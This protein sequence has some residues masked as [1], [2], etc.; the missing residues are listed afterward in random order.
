LGLFIPDP[1]FYPSRNQG[2]K[3]HRI[4]DPQRC[5]QRRII[6]E[7]HI[8]FM[9]LVGGS[10]AAFCVDSKSTKVRRLN[11]SWSRVQFI[12][13]FLRLEQSKPKIF[14]SFT[15][16]GQLLQGRSQHLPL[17]RPQKPLQG[18]PQ[19]Q[20][21]DS[22]STCLQADIRDVF[23]G[24]EDDNLGRNRHPKPVICKYQ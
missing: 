14:T 7:C 16:L 24:Q 23:W 1:D 5:C 21:P 11:G 20:E 13:Q 15:D 8:H 4:P 2:S 18:G 6:H 10:K 22:P 12:Q 19:Q 17:G 9:L 3:R